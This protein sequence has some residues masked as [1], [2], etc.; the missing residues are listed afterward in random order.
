M[1]KVC[2]SNFINENFDCIIRDPHST[3]LKPHLRFLFEFNEIYHRGMG[4][5]YFNDC[6]Q[7]KI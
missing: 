5:P 4:F 7:T 6:F 2:I 3:T 1:K